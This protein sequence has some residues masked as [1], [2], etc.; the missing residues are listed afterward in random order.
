MAQHRVEH[1][2][3]AAYGPARAFA[4]LLGENDHVAL[5]NQT[6]EE[7]QQADKKLTDLSLEINRKAARTEAGTSTFSREA[8][9]SSKSK[10]AA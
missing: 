3:I 10:D 4:E 9:S 2:E 5:L 6:L 8:S 7:E 1:Y